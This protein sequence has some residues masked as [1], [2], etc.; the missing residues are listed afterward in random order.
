RIAEAHVL[1]REAFADGIGERARIGR[2]RDLRID[3][4][5]REEVGEIERLS[6]DRREAAEEALEQVPQEP[7]GAREE[8]EVADREFAVERPPNDVRVGDVVRARTDRREDGSPPG[9]TNSNLAISFEEA[10]RERLVARHE[11][12]VEAE[13]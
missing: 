1:E 13:D 2:R 12:V 3:L 11:E 10:R 7:K 4:E 6:R 5:E 9:P 8:R